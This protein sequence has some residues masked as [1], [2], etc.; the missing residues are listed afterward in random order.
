MIRKKETLT[1]SQLQTILAIQARADH[2]GNNG[3]GSKK[4]NL[5]PQITESKF[6]DIDLDSFMLF[7]E[8]VNANGHYD[9]DLDLILDLLMSLKD[10]IKISKQLESSSYPQELE[11]EFYQFHSSRAE[12]L[13]ILFEQFIWFKELQQV[14][15]FFVYSK[16]N[17]HSN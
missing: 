8:K 12:Y 13:V 16:P 17:N 6:K 9:E 15:P 14:N 7:L 1:P 2:D 10:S 4:I 3:N 11:N 5:P